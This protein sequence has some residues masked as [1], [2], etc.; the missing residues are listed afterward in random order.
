MINTKAHTE[1]A[2]DMKAAVKSGLQ[3]AK[4]PLSPTT[5]KKLL[6]QLPRPTAALS[7]RT[8]NRMG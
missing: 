8:G 1:R 4:H 3:R 5:H 6:S 7:V 2:E